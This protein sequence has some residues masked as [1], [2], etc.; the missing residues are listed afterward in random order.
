MEREDLREQAKELASKAG[1]PAK[2]TECLYDILRANRGEYCESG[3]KT[4]CT[5]VPVVQNLAREIG[6]SVREK[7][8]RFLGLFR[9]LWQNGSREEMILVAH[10]VGELGGLVDH[11]TFMEAVMDFVPAINEEEICSGLATKGL[12]YASLEHPEDVLSLCRKYVRDI[13]KWTR[14]FAVLAAKNVLKG[15]EF[16]DYDSI[17]NILSPVMTEQDADV[18]RAVVSILRDVCEKDPRRT[19]Y[20]MKDWA[21]KAGKQTAGIIRN[22]MKSLPKEEQRELEKVLKNSN[23]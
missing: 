18:R 6:P 15:K 22:G 21:K 13:E 1:N 19:F 12:A 5:P 9:T 23:H 20:F 4:F 3:V 17:L 11:Q 2:F 8:E 10:T 7:P 16:R 14:R